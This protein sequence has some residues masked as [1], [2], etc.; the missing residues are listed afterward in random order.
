MEAELLRESGEETSV[1]FLWSMN[2]R[3]G[4]ELQFYNFNHH[5]YPD[6]YCEVNELGGPVIP[7]SPHQGHHPDLVAMAFV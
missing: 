6:D 4:D 1:Q 5:T 7:G 3:A 2:A